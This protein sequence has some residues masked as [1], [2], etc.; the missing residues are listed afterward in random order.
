MYARH[1][2]DM[3]RRGLRAA[4]S[5]R[6]HQAMHTLRRQPLRGGGLDRA[7]PEDCV[8]R[9]LPV[10]GRSACPYTCIF[11]VQ[12]MLPQAHIGSCVRCRYCGAGSVQ[13]VACTP[14]SNRICECS[15]GYGAMLA[16]EFAASCS[17][18]TAGVTYSGGVGAGCVDRTV[19]GSGAIEASPCSLQHDTVCL[20]PVDGGVP[21][22]GHIVPPR[23][24]IVAVIRAP[25]HCSPRVPQRPWARLAVYR[26]H[27]NVFFVRP[28]RRLLCKPTEWRLRRVYQVR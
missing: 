8:A 27:P 9:S 17:A 7:A 4:D 21:R 19:C 13:S 10:T 20:W 18:C 23:A 12:Q 6:Q 15:H 5:G 22:A 2:H 1:S 25:L 16:S 11:C 28:R 3:Q 24:L 26:R 14:T